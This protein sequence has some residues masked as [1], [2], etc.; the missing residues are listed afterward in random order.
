MKANPR[1]RATPLS[2]LLLTGLAATAALSGCVP[3]P[4]S[5][6]APRPGTTHAPQPRPATPTAPPPSPM[7]A[8]WRDAPQTPGN[9]SYAGNGAASGA[10]FGNGQFIVQCDTA[11]TVTLLRAAAPRA[12]AVG[13]SITSSTGA[14][15]L[16]GTATPRGVVV[17]LPARDSALDAM[18]FSRGRFAVLVTGEPTLY[19]P[20][21]TEISRVIE[22]CR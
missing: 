6:P 10:T 2:A 17:T 14:R 18:A 15:A 16:T 21:W 7:A 11:R 20:S 5:T 19:L 3:P 22:D 13:M 8:D 12:G 9:W 1:S 4:P